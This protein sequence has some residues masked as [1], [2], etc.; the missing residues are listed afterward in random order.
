MSIQ[1]VADYVS[2]DVETLKKTYKHVIPGALVS[3]HREL[4][5]VKEM[6]MR[7]EEGAPYLGGIPSR[8]ASQ[9]T[10]RRLAAANACLCTH[11][12]MECYPLQ[13][14]HQSP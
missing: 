8:A 10:C 4:T 14:P 13:M 11:L 9:G 1:D 7:S 6:K 12:A 5:A 2:T 3:C